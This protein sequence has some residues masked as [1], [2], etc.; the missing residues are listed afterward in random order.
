[1]NTPRTHKPM[2]NKTATNPQAPRGSQ[3]RPAHR[4]QALRRTTRG[5][6]GGG[7]AMS[8]TGAF[9]SQRHRPPTAPVCCRIPEAVEALLE[10]CIAFAEDYF[11]ADVRINTAISQFGCDHILANCRAPG[12]KVRLMT[13]CNTG[14]L[15]TTQ[16]GTALGVIRFVH[17]AEQLERVYCTETRPYNQV[18]LGGGGGGNSPGGRGGRR[19]HL[20]QNSVYDINRDPVGPAWQRLK[21]FRC[22]PIVFVCSVNYP[23]ASLLSILTERY[24]WSCRPLTSHIFCALFC[25]PPVHT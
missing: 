3:T 11:R 21:A 6:R 14:A 12:A 1:M 20:S 2:L 25:L 7:G 5:A 18:C 16:Y 8:I 13:H 10:S 24:L 9:A 17:T 22:M 15:A 4:R 23:R 19:F